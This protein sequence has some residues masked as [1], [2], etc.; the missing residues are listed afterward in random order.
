[1]N[2]ITIIYLHEEQTNFEYASPKKE[3]EKRK[4]NRRKNSKGRLSVTFPFN[5]PMRH[6]RGARRRWLGRVVDFWKGDRTFTRT[7][8][9][10][11]ENWPRPFCRGDDA[12]SGNGPAGLFFSN[13][14][15]HATSKVL[16]GCKTVCNAISLPPW[17]ACAFPRLAPDAILTRAW[18]LG[19]LTIHRLLARLL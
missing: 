15:Y 18:K 10:N 11:E 4:K 14:R 12:K 5:P 7:I 17:P 19:K 2:L 16:L 13:Y 1:M 3:R 8:A 9:G 6:R